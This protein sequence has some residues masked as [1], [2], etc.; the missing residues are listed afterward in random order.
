MRK[1]TLLTFIATAL[2]VSMSLIHLQAEGAAT[3][4]GHV[5]P[6]GTIPTGDKATLVLEFSTSPLLGGEYVDEEGKFKFD[7]H[8]TLRLDGQTS[9]KPMEFG[10]GFYVKPEAVRIPIRVELNHPLTTGKWIVNATVYQQMEHDM[11]AVDMNPNVWVFDVIQR[12]APEKNWLQLAYENSATIPAA[13]VGGV[14]LAVVLILLK[15]NHSPGPDTKSQ[16]KALK[17][18]QHSAVQQSKTVKEIMAES[19][20]REHSEKIGLTIF[21]VWEGS[22][23][24][25]TSCSYE[26]GEF[27]L[28]PGQPKT[29]KE[30]PLI[31]DARKHLKIVRP[32]VFTLFEKAEQS[33]VAICSDMTKAYDL[34]VNAVTGPIT[35]SCPSVPML[36]QYDSSNMHY[37]Y[38]KNL[39]A[40][41]SNELQSSASCRNYSLVH[42]VTISI[43]DAQSNRKHFSIHTL[44][45]SVYGIAWGNK[46]E[47]NQMKITLDRL[48]RDKSIED[49][50]TKLIAFQK[51][52]H[53]PEAEALHETVRKI[54][55][56]SK[57]KPIGGP[58]CCSTCSW[59][60]EDAIDRR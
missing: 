53:T 51:V 60:F 52:L 14:I 29:S 24:Q 43:T 23:R 48:V 26:N 42:P 33:A 50:F 55:N 59:L 19:P 9:L 27:R 4:N 28:K 1:V 16:I 35:S 3:I 12:P 32:E 57:E 21:K 11:R 30:F 46:E 37:C 5:E 13:V 49:S 18:Q 58:G 8:A 17:E 44:E 54:A 2:L 38:K 31:D 36:D 25:L 47:M 40:A 45:L 6:T 15:L 41:V 34:F 20:Y 10:G 22:S 56:D 7:V 39:I